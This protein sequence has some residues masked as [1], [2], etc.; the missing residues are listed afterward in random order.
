MISKLVFLCIVPWSVL[1]DDAPSS[2]PSAPAKYEYEWQVVDSYS[3]NNYGQQESRDGAN[4][5]GS[6]FVKLPDGRTQRVSYTVD[7]Y[8]GYKAT[9]TYE[10]EA[11]PYEAQ[12]SSYIPVKNTYRPVPKATA[13]E[14]KPAPPPPAPS[15]TVKP[16]EV[17]YK[18][19]EDAPEPAVYYKPLPE[20]PTKVYYKPVDA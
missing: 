15:T 3:N 5:V 18:P 10:G 13:K 19:I 2:Y 9:V 8:G 4:T 11:I 17:Y 16:G 6:Y 20:E 14:D 1:A 7:D 12:A